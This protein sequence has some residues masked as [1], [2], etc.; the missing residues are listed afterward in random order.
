MKENSTELPGLSISNRW[1]ISVNVQR[2]RGADD[3]RPRRRCARRTVGGQPPRPAAPTPRW[4]QSGNP[5]HATR[6][7]LVARLQPMSRRWRR[8]IK[9]APCLTL[10]ESSQDNPA[11]A[12]VEDLTQ[13]PLASTV[14]SA[15]R[16]VSPGRFS[17]GQFLGMSR[18]VGCRCARSRSGNVWSSHWPRCSQSRTARTSFVSLIGPIQWAGCPLRSCAEEST[19]RRCV[20]TND[21]ALTDPSQRC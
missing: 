7:Q 1:L 13:T 6:H 19:G 8:P 16:R 5:C 15:Y 20:T 14:G 10:S 12:R 4:G 18:W 2:R 21:A 17:L 3:E 9:G 11:P